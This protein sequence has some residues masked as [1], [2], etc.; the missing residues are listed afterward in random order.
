MTVATA[1]L[2]KVPNYVNG[3]W[4]DSKATEWLD[5]TNPA[6]GEVI[7]Q[8]PLSSAAEVAAAIE[9]AAS[10]F[11][12]WRRTPAEDRIQPLFKLKHILEDQID[13][14]AR[15]LT[16]ENGKTFTEAKA[17]LR[18]AIENVEVACGIPTMMQGYN[19]ED[20]ARGIDETMIRQPL[21]VVAAIVPFNF[22][23]MI[24][25]WFLPYAIATGNTFVLKP[26]ERVPLTML[27]AYELM[28]KIGLPKGV[29]NIGN[30]SK[31]VVNALL[32]HPKVRAISFVGSTPV[33]RYVYARAGEHGKRAQC[34]GGAKNHVI[35]LPDADMKMT[36]QIIGDSAFGCAGQRCLAVSV[37][38]TVGEAQ[39]T[40]RDAITE[41]AAS[42]RVGNGLDEGVQMGPVIT[43]QSKTRVESLVGQGEK[44]GAKVLLD[45]REAKIPGCAEGNFMKP[46][47][48]D[49]V[50][51]ESDLADTEIFGPVLSLV[52]AS[53]M[54]EALAFLERSPYGNQASLFTSSGSAARR[55]RYEAPA[56][57]IGINIGVAAPM[58]Y[59][60]FSGW[61]DSFFGIVHGQGRDSVEFYTEKKVVVERWAKEHSRKF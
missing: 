47:V 61:K 46:T 52:H 56:G 2:T 24:P 7:A 31:T 13:D 51:A 29:V 23:G 27:R 34:Q 41:A 53:D 35:V 12:E 38:V 33:A 17:E 16:T 14:L 8:T 40:F 58:A 21:G 50:P 37:A 32:D 6:T 26:S 20:V 5:V 11:P 57:N 45:G 10:A 43:P 54:D 28:E 39:K 18:R 22:P 1:T 36:T 15:V 3:Q 25:F 19:L 4:V 9:A 59:F 60:P 48:L 30:G 55:F 49:A 42:L 44:Q